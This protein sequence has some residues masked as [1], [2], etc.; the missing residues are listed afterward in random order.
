MCFGLKARRTKLDPNEPTDAS[1]KI[2][3]YR[4]YLKKRDKS[5]NVSVQDDLIYIDKI[6]RTTVKKYDDDNDDVLPRPP[7]VE[8]QRKVSY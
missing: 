7:P 5:E 1:Y 4:N 8:R 3:R 2:F 6:N